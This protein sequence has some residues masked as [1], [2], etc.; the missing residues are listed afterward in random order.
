VLVGP[1]NAGKSSLINAL[2][3][4][5][6]AIVS[7]EAGTTRDMIEV[8]LD[9]GGYPFTVIDT[10]GLREAEGVVEREGVRRARARAGSADLVLVLEDVTATV[11]MALFEAERF[12]VRVGTKVDLVDSAEERARLSCVFDMLVSAETGEGLDAL[13]DALLV[14]ARDVMQPG[15]SSL[16]TRSRHR[17]ALASCRE[18][19]L[20]SGDSSL[21]LE[22]RA[23]ELRHA[24]DEL[25][26]LTGRIDVE[27]LLDVIFRDF[28]IGK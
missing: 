6:V 17:A 27:D 28:C 24:S 25:G 5:D 4:R 15:E 26:R 18:A 10:A 12:T 8:R 7:P 3:K 21:P 14:F 9:I 1:V 16:I 11:P 23:E 13:L 22:L 19:L 20:R 2:A